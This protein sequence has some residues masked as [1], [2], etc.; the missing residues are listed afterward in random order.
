MNIAPPSKKVI[1]GGVPSGTSIAAAS[2][3]AARTKN[4]VCQQSLDV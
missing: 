2:G 3:S 1:A 4:Q